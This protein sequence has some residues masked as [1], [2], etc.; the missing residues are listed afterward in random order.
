[1]A[2][3]DD[4]SV[5]DSNNAFPPPVKPGVHDEEAL[6]GRLGGALALPEE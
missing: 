2:I 3:V 4:A 6:L 1:M 5:G